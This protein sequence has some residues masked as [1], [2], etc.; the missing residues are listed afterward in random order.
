MTTERKHPGGRHKGRG[1]NCV[2]HGAYSTNPLSVLPFWKKHNAGNAARVEEISTSFFRRLCWAREHPCAS[3]ITEL[4]IRI[5][6]R[7]A[8]LMKVIDMDFTRKVLDPDTGKTIKLRPCDQISKLFQLDDEI[9]A[10]MIRLGLLPKGAGF[11]GLPEDAP[12]HSNKSHS[13]INKK[14]EI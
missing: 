13:N 14:K 12:K 9:D 8:L 7:G 3:E 2:R 1:G 11:K 5:V 6:S 4:A 10:R